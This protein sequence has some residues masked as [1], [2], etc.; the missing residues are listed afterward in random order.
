[1]FVACQY[2]LTVSV[3]QG[4]ESARGALILFAD[5][6]GAS[7]FEDLSKLE[8]A[9]ANLVG[10]DV[11][12]N[13]NE[14]SDSIAMVIGS[15]AHLEKESLATRSVFRCVLFFLLPWWSLSVNWTRRRRPRAYVRDGQQHPPEYILHMLQ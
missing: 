6:D 9:L 13:P 10:H 2:L 3:I 5:A 8:E 7:K 15:R 11:T 1:M 12:K 4:I 14:V